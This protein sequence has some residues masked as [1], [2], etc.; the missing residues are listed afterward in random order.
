MENK[1]ID[2]VAR[3][4]RRGRFNVQTGWRRLGIARG[5]GMRRLRVAAAVAG[6]VILSATAAILYKEYSYEH[7]AAPVE[8]GSTVSSLAEIKVIDFEKAALPEVVQRIE[9]V[10]GVTVGNLPEHAEDYVLSLHYEGN[11]A[12]LIAIINETLGTQ[13]TVSER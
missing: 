7:T 13:L 8:I 9:S 6:A 5:I 4:Y 2:F 11:P 3:H 1:N 10:Y 12:E